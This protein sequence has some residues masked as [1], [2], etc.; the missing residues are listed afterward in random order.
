MQLEDLASKMKTENESRKFKL[1]SI[2]NNNI[3]LI[4]AINKTGIKYEIIHK[5][6]ELGLTF[7]HFK[8]LVHRARLS[9]NSSRER[10]G[11][12]QKSNEKIYEK[13][14]EVVTQKN[15]NSKDNRSEEQRI[16][17]W[18]LNTTIRLPI[19]I[20]NELEENQINYEG[21]LSLNIKTNTQ[22]RKHLSKLKSNKKYLR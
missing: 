17:D 5:S 16:T 8:N 21:F 7:T 15:L 6:I 3:E 19:S 2:F 18:Q 1:Q 11:I 14:K 12:V 9:C 10:Q 22:I 4:I 20:I 13:K